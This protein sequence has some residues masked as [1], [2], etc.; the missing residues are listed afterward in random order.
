MLEKDIMV[1]VNGDDFVSTADGKDLCWFGKVLSSKFDIKTK[2]IGHEDNDDKSV[3]I[4]NRIITVVDDGSEAADELDH[5]RKHDEENRKQQMPQWGKYTQAQEIR[6]TK[7]QIA[8]RKVHSSTRG[9][10]AV[11]INSMGTSKTI[12]A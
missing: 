4:L 8:Q 1:F 3:R 11:W 5:V 6:I 2:I 7:M 10:S 9:I 12:S